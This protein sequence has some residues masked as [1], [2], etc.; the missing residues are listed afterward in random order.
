MQQ[1]MGLMIASYLIVLNDPL[2]I[3]KA[4]D[5]RKCVFQI[6]KV[7]IAVKIVSLQEAGLVHFVS[8]GLCCLFAFA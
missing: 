2:I 8:K 5:A 3:Y 6:V 1:P 7:T 4:S